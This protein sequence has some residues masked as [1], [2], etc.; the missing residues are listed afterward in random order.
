MSKNAGGGA[1]IPTRSVRRVF[2]L[3]RQKRSDRSYGNDGCDGFSPNFPLI[4]KGAEPDRVS[5]SIVSEEG[6]ALSARVLYHKKRKKARTNRYSLFFCKGI[7]AVFS[8]LDFF[9]CI[10]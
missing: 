1:A 8:G 4:R 2:R 6:F 7:P 5:Y 10:C 3:E 9:V